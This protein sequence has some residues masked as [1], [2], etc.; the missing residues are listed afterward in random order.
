MQRSDTPGTRVARTAQAIAELSLAAQ[1]GDFLG[2]EEDLLQRFSVSRPTLR[3]ASKIAENDRLVDVRRGTKGGVYA[4]RPDAG[5]AI[6]QLARYL[7]LRGATMDHIR[8]V[9]RLIS[10]EAAALAARCRDPGLRARLDGFA[11]TIDRIDTAGAMVRAEVEL[12]TLLAQMSGN[13]AIE[14]VMAIDYTFGM[15][16]EGLRLF[17]TDE[18]RETMRS[19]QRALCRA[20]LDGDAEVARRM[21]RRRAEAMGRWIEEASTK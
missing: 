20:I 19:Q 18:Q 1:E 3:Q 13:P 6:R 9:N 10:A 4:A 21:M 17:G 15:A 14:L 5:D 12:A 2:A 11:G 7:R 8:A 16:E